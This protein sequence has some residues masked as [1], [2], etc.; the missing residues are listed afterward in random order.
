VGAC[1]DDRHIDLDEPY[2]HR[3][4]SLERTVRISVLASRHRERLGSL[5]P[6]EEP[7][8]AGDS[9]AVWSPWVDAA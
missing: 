7:A 4:Q 9:R 5:Q 6:R 2:C 3:Y 1:F 8:E